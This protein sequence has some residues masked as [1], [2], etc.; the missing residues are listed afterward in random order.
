MFKIHVS[1]VNFKNCHRI[2]KINFVVMKLENFLDC[3][4]LTYEQN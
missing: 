1:F 3:K 2:L 4:P